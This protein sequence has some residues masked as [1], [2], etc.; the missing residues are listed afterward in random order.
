MREFSFDFD[1]NILTVLSFSGEKKGLYVNSKWENQKNPFKGDMVNAYNDGPLAD[2]AQLGPFF[3][4]VV[5]TFA[6]G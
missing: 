6:P 2:G 1:R 5:A 3:N 4:E